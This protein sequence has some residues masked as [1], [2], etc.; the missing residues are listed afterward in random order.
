MQLTLQKVLQCKDEA[1]FE[2]LLEKGRE[3]GQ[4]DRYIMRRNQ[5]SF[6]CGF[7]FQSLL[8][9]LSFHL[10]T[11]YAI[12]RYTYGICTCICICTSYYV[13]TRSFFIISASAQAVGT[14]IRGVSVGR[15]QPRKVV[16]LRVGLERV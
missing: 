5:P 9:F 3:R 2:Q 13:Y 10:I 11:E 7:D 6:V 8:H 15:K 14:E 1:S 12:L 16:G 4:Y